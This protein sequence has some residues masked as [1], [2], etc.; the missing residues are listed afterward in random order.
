MADWHDR[1][2][3]QTG[4]ADWHAGVWIFNFSLDSTGVI[5]QHNFLLCFITCLCNEHVVS[6]DKGLSLKH[7]P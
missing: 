5:G 1:L 4:M 7:V 6:V 2:A 3:W